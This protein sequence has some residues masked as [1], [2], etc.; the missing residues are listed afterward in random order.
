MRPWQ[1]PKV[2][3]KHHLIVS[4]WQLKTTFVV[5][6]IVC[7]MEGQRPAITATGNRT[8]FELTNMIRLAAR[9]VDLN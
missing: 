9:L 4:V 1:L 5:A 2:A 3:V 8:I 7:R 6:N